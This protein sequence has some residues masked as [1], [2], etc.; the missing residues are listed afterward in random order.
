MNEDFETN[1]ILWILFFAASIGVVLFGV[2]FRAPSLVPVGAIGIAV[3][4]LHYWYYAED[5][6]QFYETVDWSERWG[7]D[8]LLPIPPSL[9]PWVNGAVMVGVAVML[10]VLSTQL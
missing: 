9:Q 3:T 4:G 5:Y 6:V 2:L 1:R 8:P 7:N 10:V